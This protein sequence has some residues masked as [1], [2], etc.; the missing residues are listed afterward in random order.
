MAGKRKSFIVRGGADFSKVTKGMKGLKKDVGSFGKGL[1]KLFAVAL[2]ALGIRSL[3]RFTREARAAFKRLAV[4]QQRLANV[5]RSSMGATDSAIK[6]TLDLIRRQSNLGVVSK[7]AFTAGAQAL[8][9]FTDGLEELKHALP[10]LGNLAVA[11]HGVNVTSQQMEKT[12]DLFGRA[13]A[14]NKQALNRLGV[15][16]N[17]TER[18][19]MRLGSSYQRMAVL[20]RHINTGIGDMNFKLA[21]TDIGR[22]RQLANTFADIR[23]QFGAAFNQIAI[24]FLPALNAVA[25]AL[26]RVASLARQVAQLIAGTFG[27]SG[28]VDDYT[29]GMK[30]A[31]GGAYRAA[32]AQ[33]AYGYA[34]AEAAKKA[35][36]SLQSFDEVNQ[37][38]NDG[39][40]SPLPNFYGGGGIFEGGILGD[41]DINP[42]VYEW[43]NKIADAAKRLKE[44]LSPIINIFGKI[45]DWILEADSALGI[46]IRSLAA[47]GGYMAAKKLTFYAVRTAWSGMVVYMKKNG[48]HLT[49]ML[50]QD[51]MR[52]CLK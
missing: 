8:A 20:T 7:D 24:L 40:E 14:G 44:V 36:N 18:D 16:L 9:G 23:I 29:S 35:K 50:R 6:S 48:L 37:L 32:D 42:K 22:Q 47:F 31:A 19:I 13:L 25:N 1:K 52:L 5:M 3:F 39:G 11:Q 33:E 28:A 21:Q 10:V 17:D 26:A 43:F 27:G 49:F 12:A 30:N 51:G 41:V 45:K 15:V 34:V 46:F 38:Q 2:G 4:D